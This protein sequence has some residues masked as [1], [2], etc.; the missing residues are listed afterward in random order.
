MG[1]KG[2]GVP[3][4]IRTVKWSDA[5]KEFGFIEPCDGSEYAF[6]NRYAVEQSGLRELIDGQKVRYDVFPGMDGKAAAE[7]LVILD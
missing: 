3:M 1:H 4:A 5:T 7:N 6:V 2:K